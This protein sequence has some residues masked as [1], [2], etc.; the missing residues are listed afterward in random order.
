MS[1][2]PFPLRA[3][4]TSAA[5]VEWASGVPFN[6][7]LLLIAV[8]PNYSGVTY[9][10]IALRNSSPKLNVPQRYKINIQEGV[11]DTNSK[12][13]LTTSLVPTNILYSAWFYDDTN[14]LIAVGP[15]LFTVTADPTTITIPT[16]TDPTAAVVSPNPEAV[17]NTTVS[18]II[19]NAPEEESLG[20]TQNGVNLAF[21][22]SHQGTITF[23]L[24][25]GA[26]ITPGVDYTQSGV[27]ITFTSGNA[28][29]VDDIL[30]AVI[31]G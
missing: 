9:P 11:I 14:Q 6:G 31:F 18:T 8:P 28:P 22:V 10:N 4:L 2:T 17:P 23:I 21:T 24:R 5:T 3:G 1:T 27:N 25:N 13:W 15:A 19:Y 12:V 30:K 29:L 7:W 16:L 20:G 26:I